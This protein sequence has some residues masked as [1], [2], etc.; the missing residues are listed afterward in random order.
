MKIS[1]LSARYGFNATDFEKFI[2]QNGIH[3]NKVETRVFGESRYDAF[4]DDSDVANVV[5][6][7]SQKI[8]LENSNKIAKN[9]S[10][11]QSDVATI[12]FWVK[13]W[14]IAGIVIIGIGVLI[15]IIT[16]LS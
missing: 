15:G 10:I 9:I 14:S 7:Y 5:K 4:I 3:T 8:G 13:F 1:E 12:R 11:M 16:A 2:V 6:L